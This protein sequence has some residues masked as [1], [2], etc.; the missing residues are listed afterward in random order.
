VPSIAYRASESRAGLSDRARSRLN[1]N[2]QSWIADNQEYLAS[3]RSD[4]A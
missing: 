4:V 2:I 1:K 3:L